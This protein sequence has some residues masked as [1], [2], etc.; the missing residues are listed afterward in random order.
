MDACL[1]KYLLLCEP[2]ALSCSYVNLL[3][4]CLYAGIPVVV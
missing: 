4:G 3:H 2:V 1:L